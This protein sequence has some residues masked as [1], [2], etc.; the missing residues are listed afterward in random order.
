MEEVVLEEPLDVF[1]AV[2]GSPVGPGAVDEVEEG[3]VGDSVMMCLV[4]R[5]CSISC[6]SMSSLF[7]S[8]YFF[9]SPLLLSLSS[10]S[11]FFL[12]YLF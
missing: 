12:S 1:A 9:S 6:L 8:S 11:N 3:E 5:S 7:F 4:S 2:D 10:P